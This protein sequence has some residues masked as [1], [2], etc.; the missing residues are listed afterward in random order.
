MLP[1]SLVSALRAQCLRVATLHR[2][3]IL[4]GQGYA[5]MPDALS[6]KFPSAQRS[7][8]WQ[9]V[10]PS[11]TERFGATDRRWVRWHLSPASLQQA[12]RHAAAS[13]PNLPH[14]T[15]HRLR[16]AFATHLLESGT[17]VRTIQSLL[18]HANLETT[19]LYTHVAHAHR[20]VESPLERLNALG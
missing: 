2:D 11:A 10:F 20:G 15:V 8:S 17:D 14:A 19:M 12:F 7:L 3:R 16:H 4:R 9:L 6:R 13:V 1:S 5:P 18:G